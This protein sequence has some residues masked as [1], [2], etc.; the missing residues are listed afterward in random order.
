MAFPSTFAP[1]KNAFLS[2]GFYIRVLDTAAIGTTKVKIVITYSDGTPPNSQSVNL[3]GTAAAPSYAF[4]LITNALKSSKIA[5]IKILVKFASSTGVLLVDNLYYYYEADPATR[6][7]GLLP[8]PVPP[9][10]K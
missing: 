8:V 9:A 1:R 2:G 10:A 4:R 6:G 7:S 3:A 5:S